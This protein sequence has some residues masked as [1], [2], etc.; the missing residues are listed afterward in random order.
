[1]IKILHLDLGETLVHGNSPFPHVPQAL[2]VLNQFVTEAGDPLG[3]G[4]VS[5][6]DMPATPGNAAQ[7]AQ[8]FKQYLQLLEGFGLRSYFEPVEKR[9]TLSTHAGKKKPDPHV[10]EVAG[11]R[12]GL[13]ASF[14]ERLFIT[15]DPGHISKARA[16]GMEALQFG[17]AAGSDFADWSAGPLLIAR[18]VTPSKHDNLQLALDLWLRVHKNGE[19]TELHATTTPDLFQIQANVWVALQDASLGSLQNVEVTIPC[20]GAVKLTSAGSVSSAQLAADADAIADATGYVKTLRD[21][22]Q[23][24]TAPGALAPGTTHVLDKDEQGRQRLR[25]QRFSAI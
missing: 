17:T 23:I 9:V 21:N 19:L 18:R 22:G 7:V 14:S 3:V 2:D 6:F 12:L 8:I 4:L 20:A 10:F 1:M 13:T 16:L 11:Q 24:S 5:D 15:E 25:R